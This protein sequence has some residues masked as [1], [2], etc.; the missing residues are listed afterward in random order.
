MADEKTENS[1]LNDRK[2]S[3]TYLLLFTFFMNASWFTTVLTSTSYITISKY[4]YYKLQSESHESY[5]CI[6]CYLQVG[7]VKISQNFPVSRVIFQY[8]I[9]LY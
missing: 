5:F 1:S 6:S 4:L 9:Y 2:H 3:L 8:S 7:H